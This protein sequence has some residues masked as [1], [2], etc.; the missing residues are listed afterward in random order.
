MDDGGKEGE[1]GGAR[2]D[3]DDDNDNNNGGKGIH[4][5]VCVCCY[6]NASTD[7]TL[8]ALRSLSAEYEDGRGVAAA[9]ERSRTTRRMRLLVGTASFPSFF[10]GRNTFDFLAKGVIPCVFFFQLFS[11]RN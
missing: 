8:S 9:V 10:V 11:G 4:L 7:G 2:V 5:D 3:D 6:D 1:G